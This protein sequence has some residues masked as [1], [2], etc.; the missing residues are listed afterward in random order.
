MRTALLALPFA[1]LL[2]GCTTRMPVERLTVDFNQSVAASA[3]EVTLLNVLRAKEYQPLHFTSISLARGSMTAA[4]GATLGAALNDAT[5]S[6]ASGPD[7]QG[8]LR[9][10]TRT[11]GAAVQNVTPGISFSAS[12][13]PS[14]DVSVYD[15]QEF[16]NGI[17]TALP[18]Q[19]VGHLLYQ[20]WPSSFIGY[21]LIERVEFRFKHPSTVDG[22]SYE[23]DDIAF[24]IEN[25][26]GRSKARDRR[27]APIV[28]FGTGVPGFP[29]RF[30]P[31]PVVTARRPGQSRPL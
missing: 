25:D 5:T 3:N 2:P 24:A 29:E 4:A 11:V 6:I 20:G 15:T 31:R 30:R 9:T 13:N 7:D 18:A 8:I 21:L 28:A 17:T 26:P 12:V 14:F 19:T 27:G 10:S 16:Y 1:T 23:E 22:A